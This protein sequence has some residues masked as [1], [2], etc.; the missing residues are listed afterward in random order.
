[1]VFKYPRK[2]AY[3]TQ[4]GR[5]TL[6]AK[7]RDT[8]KSQTER[9]WAAIPFYVNVDPEN[10]TVKAHDSR[11]GIEL[12]ADDDST[13]IYNNF[14][15]GLSST[16]DIT[17]TPSENNIYNPNGDNIY[18]AMLK[19]PLRLPNASG[20]AMEPV[21]LY[22]K[23]LFEGLNTTLNAKLGR[24]YDDAIF[25]L[26]VSKIMPSDKTRN[27]RVVEYDNLVAN[28][29]L[30]DSVFYKKDGTR[31]LNAF[32]QLTFEGVNSDASYLVL[33]AT[34]YVIENN[35][36]GG[37][38]YEFPYTNAFTI[39]I[40]IKV[41]NTRPRLRTALD[42]GENPIDPPVVELDALKTETVDLNKLFIDDDN[43]KIDAASHKIAEVKVAEEEYIQLDK[44]GNVKSAVNSYID[45]EGSTYTAAYYNLFDGT[46]SNLPSAAV[47]ANALT[48]GVLHV[49]GDAYSTGFQRWYISQSMS[50][51]NA[52]VQYSFS[53]ATLTLTGLRATY[54]LY[55]SARSGY[56]TI[57]S[58][59]TK[60][61]ITQDDTEADKAANAGDFY[62]LVRLID[63]NDTSDMGI[64]LPIGIRVKNTA[65]TD[66]S[67]ERN[68]PGASELPT[69]E[70]DVGAE[71]YFT[72]MGITYNRSFIPLGKYENS[73]G[74]LDDTKLRALGS[75]V[76]NFYTES[77]D[78]LYNGVLNELLTAK[79]TADEVMR[80][81]DEQG[82]SNELYYTVTEIPIY[83]P[84]TYF[85]TGSNKARLALSDYEGKD[86]GTA[87]AGASKFAADYVAIRGY[88]ITLNGWTHNRY[89]FAPVTLVDSAGDEV[90]VDIAVK[91]NNSTPTGLKA[92]EADKSE[93]YVSEYSYTNSATGVSSSAK[94]DA[95]GEVPTITYNI[96]IGSSVIVTPYDILTDVNMTDFGVK[97][98][99]V[100]V[101][102]DGG[103]KQKNV[104][105]TLNGI[106]G[107]YD[108]G[109][110]TVNSS[111]VKGGTG[112]F[113]GMANEDNAISGGFDYSSAEY[114]N[115]LK[116]TLDGITAT[117]NIA[118]VSMY[119]TF[120]AA[121]AVDYDSVGIDGLYFE[122]TDDASHL[123]GFTFNPYSASSASRNSFSTPTITNGTYVSRSFGSKLVFPS[124]FFDDEPNSVSY[125][126]DF[127]ILTGVTRTP[128]NNAAEYT[129]TVRDR[130]GASATGAASGIKTFKIKVNVVNSTPT[131]R[132]DARPITL[133]T[134]VSTAGEYT[135]REIE[136]EKILVDN[137][138]D[139]V[140][141]HTSGYKVIDSQDREN[142][143]LIG[144]RRYLGSYVDV[145]ITET[146]IKVTALNSSQ[147]IEGL[148]L[149]FKATDGR[150]SD[151][152]SVLRLR[153]EVFNSAPTANVGGTDGFDTQYVTSGS[154]I[155]RIDNM[156]TVSST[157][158]SDQKMSR[159]FASGE[160]AV[161]AIKQNIGANSTQIKRIINDTD[162]LQGVV[163]SPRVEA[164]ADMDGGSS[165]QPDSGEL[166]KYINAPA[167]TDD[168]S[169][170]VPYATEVISSTVGTG[171]Y[172]IAVKIS[173]TD[174]KGDPIY[175]DT[176][177]N[178]ASFDVVYFVD[179]D[180]NGTKETYYA[181]ALRSSDPEFGKASF[182]NEKHE[183][184][185]DDKGRWTVTDWAVEIRPVGAFP[186][187]KYFTIDIKM[188]DEVK[189]GGDSAGFSKVS[190]YEYIKTDDNPDEAAG[191]VLRDSA[192]NGFAQ[193]AYHL[194]IRETG[195][196][197]YDYYDRFDGLYTVTDIQDP[198][199]SYI[200]TYDGDSVG[201]TYP[202]GQKALYYTESTDSVG[203]Y[204]NAIEARDY[205]DN[206]NIIK[207]R[208]SGTSDGT[209]AGVNSGAEYTGSN[210]EA[211][212][213]GA[214]RYSHTIEV[215]DTGVTYIPMSY[216]ALNSSVIRSFGTTV[217]D[218]GPVYDTNVYVA[219]NV[220][221]PYDRSIFAQ[222]QEAITISDGVNT[223]RGSGNQSAG[224]LPLSQN[225]YVQ[226][227]AYDAT[228]SNNVLDSG[229]TGY[230]A[231]QESLNSAYF[232]KNIA[233]NTYTNDSTRGYIPI[234]Q[235][236][237]DGTGGYVTGGNNPNL[238]NIV[239]EEGRILHLLDQQTKLQEHLFGISLQKSTT[240][241][242]KLSR[243]KTS[244]IT[245]TIDVAWCSLSDD[246]RTVSAGSQSEDDD[247]DE[248]ADG[249]TARVSFNLHIG[250]S[251]LTLDGSTDN[252]ADTD[253][254]FDKDG[255]YYY[256]EA[257]MK[258]GDNRF[259]IGLVKKGTTSGSEDG[260]P[261][262]VIKYVD[263]DAFDSAQFS[264]ESTYKLGNW[265]TA[266]SYTRVLELSGQEFKNTN[267]DSHAQKSMLNYFGQDASKSLDSASI[268]SITSVFQPNGGIYGTNLGTS[269]SGRE[270]YSR[271]FGLSLSEDATKLYI[272]PYAKTI[273]NPDVY[274]DAKG[275]AYQS[276]V[277]SLYDARGLV[278]QFDDRGSVVSAYYP[279]KILVYDD[280]GDGWA[281][282]S[283]VALEVRVYVEN[284]APTFTKT[285]LDDYNPDNPD[286]PSKHPG[287]KVINVSLAVDDTYQFNLRDVIQDADLLKDDYGN[288]AWKGYYLDTVNANAQ[289]SGPNQYE[290][291]L[292]AD[293]GDY[294]ASPF[295]MEGYLNS[296][297]T[298]LIDGRAK[299]SDYNAP[300]SSQSDIIMYMPYV[301]SGGNNTLTAD[302]IPLD[303][304]V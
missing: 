120:D 116:P 208:Q 41:D 1:E 268:G 195:I 16:D 58:G 110:L 265:S 92:N 86:A 203:S 295:A 96:P 273:I 87:Y 263:S 184:F 204:V 188:R 253:V 12:Y 214:F 6:Y 85:G 168:Y 296:G 111:V 196:V 105:F 236:F 140:S 26:D 79:S 242:Q 22:A 229:S 56:K 95:T 189:Y 183:Y 108:D 233:I 281:E 165:I 99:T 150:D 232:N 44:Y 287:D 130:T 109:T 181:S 80:V 227:N 48:S 231:Y 135:I 234:Q 89:L 88:K 143:G 257:R 104:G 302:S 81:G 39:E 24:E 217:S 146:T 193:I 65:P 114:M 226:I 172:P 129:M 125:G 211:E 60:A 301:T 9:G 148:Y 249:Q 66:V 212:L 142:D 187:K 213:K 225:P 272:T 118:A 145:S 215:P 128:A 137:E 64:W 68:Q 103:P 278:P 100:E 49:E 179:T 285:L 121:S 267:S 10:V 2:G 186:L 31:I 54:P 260:A 18:T 176:P 149:E 107:I 282:A 127:I 266:S 292:K 197:T 201:S 76:D 155:H 218:F 275:Y 46:D 164:G 162:A 290:W 67:T 163:L 243:Y 235:L 141:F 202:S 98:P 180:G 21:V 264:I 40:V 90:N 152:L 82:R 262:K 219:Y 131:L 132:D 57:I 8:Y 144:N 154:S 34:V 20:A 73:E 11:N 115:A 238:N 254:R 289:S 228:N 223:Y 279:L 175:T 277:K 62:I 29:G 191:T 241:G 59:S 112:V 35:A 209:P 32:R 250:N 75:D 156:W 133:K 74:R 170:Y 167:G 78:M 53:N 173:F 255:N 42:N 151:K 192:T 69:A 61:A 230:A 240:S 47:M 200:P 280:C 286:D 27:F 248:T 93:Y 270:G 124:G 14:Y 134:S 185:F 246:G 77:A 119:N 113:Y 15:V 269:G 126:I 288:W 71:F 245:V 3:A 63:Y 294:L 38:N 178:Y 136:A 106:R 283:Y 159:Y 304:S 160:A 207:R 247:D 157:T 28:P 161:E 97:Y 216:F 284:S 13:N 221:T 271:Y 33:P 91:V 30:P 84:K 45:G 36:A 72:P 276:A 274:N 293:S 25:S 258:N 261:N 23:D 259:E 300:K 194:N 299:F 256:T 37:N 206:T 43:A 171:N 252:N 291:M 158:Q 101:N 298:Q 210:S 19:Q 205:S 220:A 70:G 224:I 169:K 102:G 17:Q 244:D 237:K 4:D 139:K 50:S 55:K 222:F 83:I 122:R 303:N 251:K 123:D 117:R 239:G 190:D 166:R 182:L 147:N 138:N 51:G 7:V 199:K 94:Y 5:L 297:N 52:F 177:G 174:V 198:T 153:I